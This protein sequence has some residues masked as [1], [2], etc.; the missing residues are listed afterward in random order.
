MDIVKRYGVG[1]GSFYRKF[2]KNMQIAHVPWQY[3]SAEVSSVITEP[4]HS[5]RR[6][7][8]TTLFYMCSCSEHLPYFCLI[9]DR[10]YVI[11]KELKTIFGEGNGTRKL[12]VHTVHTHTLDTCTMT[13][14]AKTG[15]TTKITAAP[16]RLLATHTHKLIVHLNPVTQQLLQCHHISHIVLILGSRLNTDTTR[17]TEFFTE[18]TK[19]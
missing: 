17:I 2:G 14:H 4:K 7:P 19:T 6:P 18:N 9:F 11:C 1:D 13:D 15:Y 8:P 3:A 5:H 12:D 16:F 10:K